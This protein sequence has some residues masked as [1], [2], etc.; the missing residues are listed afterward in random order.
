M[1]KA[2]WYMSTG[3][4]NMQHHAANNMLLAQY[5]TSADKLKDR[6]QRGKAGPAAT[7]FRPGA[8]TNCGAMSHMAKNCLE[9]PR[10][11]GARWTGKDIVADE[12]LHNDRLETYDS[13]RDRWDG[14][15]PAAHR[16]VIDEFETLER[17]RQKLR[18]EEVDN[19]S[20]SLAEVEKVAKR[21]KVKRKRRKDE[22][23]EDYDSFGSSDSEEDEESDAKYTESAD[24][25]G[26]K[27]DTKQVRHRYDAE[28]TA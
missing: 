19:A 18:E 4:K 14:Y 12:I 25:A 9:R 6:Y 27:L 13:K 17:E 28:L 16:A 20:A 3:E 15:D 10:K 1:S 5:E 22:K 8:C 2:P 23:D 24:Q 7:K 11:Q 21:G 26:Q